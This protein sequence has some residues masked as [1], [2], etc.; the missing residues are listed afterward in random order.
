LGLEQYH[1][2]SE[3]T[4]V[5][6]S[7]RESMRVRIGATICSNVNGCAPAVIKMRS[8]PVLVKVE[9]AAKWQMTYR[10]LQYDLLLDIV[11]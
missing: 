9:N 11:P 8:L 7:L 5:H 1:S 2:R 4:S 3:P 6:K 10:L